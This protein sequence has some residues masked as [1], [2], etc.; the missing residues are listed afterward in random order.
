MAALF[1]SLFFV[2]PLDA[3]EI[4]PG[5]LTLAERSDGYFEYL[6]RVPVRSGAPLA[7]EPVFPS[8]CTVSHLMPL[9]VSGLYAEQS[10][11]LR[12]SD[13]LKNAPIR[14]IGLETLRTDVLLRVDYR[15]AGSETARATPDNPE[16]ALRG[17]QGFLDV[18]GTYLVLGVEHILL[19]I[20]HLLFVLALLLLV[21]GRRRLVETVTAF[22]LAHSI[23]LTGATLGLISAPPRLVEVLIALSIVFVAGEVIHRLRGQNT[24]TVRKPWLI[25]FLFGLLHGFGFAGALREIGIPENAVPSALLFFNIGVE[26]GQLLFIGFIIIAIN[27]I[28][29]IY[30]PQTSHARFVTA[31]SIGIVA[32]FWALERMVAIWPLPFV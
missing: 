14:I 23:T 18:A 15:D 11:R 27:A 25:A 8:R 28:S 19:G 20:D 24:L 12:C 7:I 32:A 5:L 21:D 3:H 29:R 17:P 10:G 13:G 26:L 22:T 9:S 1:L 30:R 4:R 6:W 31:W 16:V 2:R